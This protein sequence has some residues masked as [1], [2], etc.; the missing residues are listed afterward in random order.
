VF[1]EGHHVPPLDSGDGFINQRLC[2][3]H[4]VVFY[5]MRGNA[6]VDELARSFFDRRE[7]PAR[8]MGLKPLFLIGCERNRHAVCTADI[9]LFYRGFR[10]PFCVEDLHQKR[11]FHSER[12]F[13][14][15]F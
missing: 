4:I 10:P 2:P 12:Y 6:L 9:P 7:V 13:V 3:R 1:L 5:F 15:N 14:K 11:T 8:D